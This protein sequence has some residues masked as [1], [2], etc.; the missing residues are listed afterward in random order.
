MPTLAREDA[1]EFFLYLIEQKYD[2]EIDQE[3][4]RGIGN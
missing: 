4:V 3:H 1:A 2:C